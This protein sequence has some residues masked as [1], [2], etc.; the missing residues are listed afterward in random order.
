MMALVMIYSVAVGLLL[1]LAALCGERASVFA[2][3]ARRWSW[4]AALVLTL[5]LP[6]VSLLR[7]TSGPATVAATDAAESVATVSL[8]RWRV[9]AVEEW[10]RRV[11]ARLPLFDDDNRWL[12]VAWLLTSLASPVWYV[13]GVVAL[14]RRRSGWRP[15]SMHG[16]AV[17]V[18]PE[19][20]P[21]VVGAWKPEIV[22]PEWAMSLDERSLEM[23][24]RHESEHV[25][26]G[27]HWLVHLTRLAVVVMPWNPAVWWIASRLR[28]AVE[29][30]CDARVLAPRDGTAIDASA[31]AALLLAVAE[32]PARP[33]GVMSPALI[34]SSKSLFRRIVAMCP[35][36][37]RFPRAQALLALTG[38]VA[39]FAAACETPTPARQTLVEPTGVQASEVGGPP[40]TGERPPSGVGAA[41]PAGE[42]PT[43]EMSGRPPTGETST[44]G[45]LI[46]PQTPSVTP[47]VLVPSSERTAPRRAQ[48]RAEAAAP[49]VGRTVFRPG[50]G[51]SITKPVPIEQP[52]PRYTPEAMRS[53]VQGRVELEVVVEADGTV[54]DVVVVRSLDTQFGLDA[55]AIDAAKRWRFEP[56]TLNGQ[57]VAAA[58]TLEMEFAIH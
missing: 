45:E 28:L 1:V 49:A 25:R 36:D 54:G 14:A 16:N 20:G 57:P 55:S 39:L 30:D 56:A 53:K 6:V 11:V 27:D 23:V 24:L 51:A 38:A 15:A 44:S 26:A 13:G 37:V 42:W 2:G 58:V 41:P 34:E 19:T 7:P 32:R 46:S 43:S 10:S 4:V 17:V 47:R 35:A 9:T 22:L 18:S 52:R 8:A 29:C 3:W 12:A 33:T 50:Q 21:A 48:A 31:Y 5:S 40:P